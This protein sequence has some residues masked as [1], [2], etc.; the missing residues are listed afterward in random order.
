[1]DL[2]FESFCYNKWGS[3]QTAKPGDWLVNNEGDVYSVDK[4]YFRNHYQIISQGIYEKVGAIW[5]S[6]ATQDGTITTLEGSTDYAYGDYLVFDRPQGGDAYAVNKSEFERMYEAIEPP[7]QLNHHQL[8]YLDLLNK[9]ALTLDEQAQRN[10]SGYYLVQ[11]LAII[12]AASV[13]VISA[14]S[15]L[16][17]STTNSIVALCGGLSAVFA[18]LLGIYNW[19][20]NWVCFKRSAEDLKS[21]LSQF[22]VGAGM[23]G[24]RENAFSHLV[25]NCERI[26]SEQ[27]G[28]WASHVSSKVEL[29][30]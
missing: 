16:D 17:S 3:K 18:G 23:Y 6:I 8:A 20:Q 11:T 5:A 25:E 21:H 2:P 4:E 28:Q 27:R 13:P 10:R 26:L 24:E 14:F 30:N 19:Q 7:D 22:K 1:M 15:S 29:N 12:F 9:Q